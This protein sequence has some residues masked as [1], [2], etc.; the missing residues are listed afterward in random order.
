MRL[1]NVGGGENQEDPLSGIERMQRTLDTVNGIIEKID[2]GENLSID[3]VLNIAEINKGILAYAGSMRNL[4]IMLNK[5]QQQ[6]LQQQREFF[7]Q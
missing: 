2:A 1:R 6:T 7:K 4:R 3:D 5:E